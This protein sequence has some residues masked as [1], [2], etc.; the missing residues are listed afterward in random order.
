MI[1]RDKHSFNVLAFVVGVWSERLWVKAK[2]LEDAGARNLPVILRQNI[3][4]EK[5][6]QKEISGDSKSAMET[7]DGAVQRILTV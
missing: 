1:I 5:K 7:V 2:V 6:N 3:S 4:T